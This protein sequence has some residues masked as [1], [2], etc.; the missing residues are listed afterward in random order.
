[1]F[2]KLELQMR[3]NDVKRVAFAKDVMDMTYK[4]FFSK[5]KGETQFTKKEIDILISYFNKKYEELF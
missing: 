5:L 2:E 3:I 1:M 4:T